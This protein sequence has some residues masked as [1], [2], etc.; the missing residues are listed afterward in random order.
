MKQFWL[1]WN[2]IPN[3]VCFARQVCWNC[4]RMWYVELRE[5]ARPFC[6]FNTV[7][8]RAIQNGLGFNNPDWY[9]RD[10]YIPRTCGLFLQK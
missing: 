6:I 5:E 9:E 7:V 3:Y 10:E 1:F 4:Q 8:G 2:V